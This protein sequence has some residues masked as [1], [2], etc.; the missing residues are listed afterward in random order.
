ETSWSTDGRPFGA[1]HQAWRPARGGPLR[2]AH[3]DGMVCA[4]SD[5]VGN[6]GIV[7]IRGGSD[8]AEADAVASAMVQ[9]RRGV[10]ADAVLANASQYDG[11]CRVHHDGSGLLLLA[12]GIRVRQTPIPGP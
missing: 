10:H 4:L 3:R 6:L 2:R 9:L 8:R 1:H 7:E 5:P 12:G 11:V